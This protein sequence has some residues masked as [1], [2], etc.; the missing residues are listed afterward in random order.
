MTKP[1]SLAK[2]FQSNH[3]KHNDH[4]LAGFGIDLETA[5][6]E[7]DIINRADENENKIYTPWNGGDDTPSILANMERQTKKYLNAM[8]RLTDYTKRQLE[9]KEIVDLT[10]G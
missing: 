3:W 5:L 4:K 6:I 7:A 9:I 2:Y 10:L 8:S 1:I